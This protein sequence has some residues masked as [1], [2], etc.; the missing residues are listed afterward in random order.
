MRLSELIL[1]TI[2]LLKKRPNVLAKD[3]LCKKGTPRAGKIRGRLRAMKFRVDEIPEKNRIWVFR[4]GPERF[5][6][7]EL[8]KLRDVIKENYPEDHKI[9]KT[10]YPPKAAS[11]ISTADALLL[12]MEFILPRVVGRMV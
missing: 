9:G 3:F 1:S 5:S 4:E 2:T 10:I 12:T 8:H 6:Y 7:D 11:E